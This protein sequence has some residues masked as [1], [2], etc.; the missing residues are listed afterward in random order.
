MPS[1]GLSALSETGTRPKVVRSDKV[2]VSDLIY[3]RLRHE[4]VYLPRIM[5]VFTRSTLGWHPGHL[6]S[7]LP[8]LIALDQALAEPAPEICDS[9]QDSQST[10]IAYIQMLLAVHAQPSVAESGKA[11]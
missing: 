7:W 1:T 9:D 5:D 6:L 8:T 10:A 2:W 3:I 11:S 4:L